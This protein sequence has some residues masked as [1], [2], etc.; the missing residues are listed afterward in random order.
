MICD[1]DC[2]IFNVNKLE[3]FDGASDKEYLRERFK[4]DLTILDNCSIHRLVHYVDHKDHQSVS[5]TLSNVASTK[6]FIDQMID[7]DFTKRFKIKVYPRIFL[8]RNCPYIINISRLS[9]GSTRRIFI[10]L[11]LS[12]NTDDLDEALNKI[13]Y[14]CHLVPVFTNFHAVSSLYSPEY[15]DKL[16]RIRGVGFVFS[17]FNVNDSLNLKLIEQII[18]NGNTVLLGTSAEH[19]RMNENEIHKN[20]SYLKKKLSP[21]HYRDI[22]ISSGRLF[23]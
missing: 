3:L 12:L 17:I 8:S 5:A 10:E 14:N 7:K 9:I 19:S 22:L 15:I 16:I 4:S 21:E 11:P 20:L 23:E 2:K 18:K 1:F 6:T 13:L